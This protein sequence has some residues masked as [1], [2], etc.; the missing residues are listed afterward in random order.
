VCS[1]FVGSKLSVG[2][3]GGT[4]EYWGVLLGIMKTDIE[5][6]TEVK[7]QTEKG[8]KRRILTS[9]CIYLYLPR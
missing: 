9:V 5:S 3:M 6:S 1:F 8:R 4:G 2:E 7:G